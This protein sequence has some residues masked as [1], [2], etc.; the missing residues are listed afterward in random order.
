MYLSKKTIME[1]ENLVTVGIY[2]KYV[3]LHLDINFKKKCNKF[4]EWE[5]QKVT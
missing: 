2:A 3:F 5:D 1:T 4:A